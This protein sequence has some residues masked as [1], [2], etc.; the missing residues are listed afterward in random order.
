MKSGTWLLAVFALA[1]HVPAHAD[2]AS[3]TDAA[4]QAYENKDY[5]HCADDI[6]AMNPDSSQ[7]PDGGELLQ[8]ECLAAAG[9][10]DAALHVIAEQVPYGRI[11]VADLVHKDRP[12]LNRLRA[13]GGWAAAIADAQSKEAARLARID[14]PLRKALLARGANDQGIRH[15]VIARGG[16]TDFEKETASVDRDNAAWLKKVVSEKGWPGISLVG[17]DGYRAAFYIAQHAA[18]DIPFQEQVLAM[19]QVAV[20]SHDVHPDE[21]AMLTDR[22]LVEQGKPQRY[23]TQFKNAPDGSLFMQP[24]EDVA[25]LDDRRESV[26]LEP[27]AEYKQSLSSMYHKVVK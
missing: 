10:T 20:G 5:Q 4:L 21:V 17:S 22:V 27:I 1:L 3:K 18:F 11:N 25:G 13:S 6:A 15:Q 12:G 19:M 2:I 8:V 16:A 9:N 23:G 24:T 14:Q 7:F 26:G